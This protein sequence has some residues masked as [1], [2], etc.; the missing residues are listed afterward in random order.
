MYCRCVSVIPSAS[1]E[2]VTVLPDSAVLIG[3]VPAIVAVCPDP[4]V[5][6]PLSPPIVQLEKLSAPTAILSNFEPSVARSLPSTVPPTVIFPPTVIASV[7]ILLHLFEVVPKALVLSVSGTKSTPLLRC[8]AAPV[9]SNLN[10][11]VLFEPK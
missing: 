5:L 7:K 9:V 4:T 1:I 2:I 3:A 11:H 10:C 8:T 6:V